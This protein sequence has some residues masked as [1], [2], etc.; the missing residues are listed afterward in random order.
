NR[1]NNRSNRSTLRNQ[2]NAITGRYAYMLHK[3]H[4]W[5][6]YI[7]DLL[8]VS[9]RRPNPTLTTRQKRVYKIT[10]K[11]N[12]CLV[13]RVRVYKT[14][15][16]KKIFCL[17]FRVRVAFLIQLEGLLYIDTVSRMQHIDIYWTPSYCFDY[18]I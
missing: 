18:V 3:S 14:T 7:K 1:L 15:N 9:K 13:F 4:S 8:T 5:H 16:K 11:K 12:F 17:V 6:L 2:S 10:N